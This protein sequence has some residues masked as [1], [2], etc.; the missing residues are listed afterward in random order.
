MDEFVIRDLG[1]RRECTAILRKPLRPNGTE[2]AAPRNRGTMTAQAVKSEQKKIPRVIIA[3]SYIGPTMPDVAR[4]G[5]FR[6]R[7]LGARKNHAL[8][9]ASEARLSLF[10]FLY[11]IP[12]SMLSFACRDKSRKS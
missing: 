7:V 1:L 12:D 5:R 3:L 4:R 10:V 9:A 8:V 11:R 2:L 6:A